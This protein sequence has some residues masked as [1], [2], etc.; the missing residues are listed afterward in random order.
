MVE[1]SVFKMIIDMINDDPDYI[2]TYYRKEYDIIIVETATIERC[3]S[4]YGPYKQIATIYANNNGIDVRRNNGT[5]WKSIPWSTYTDGVL[6]ECLTDLPISIQPCKTKGLQA[7]TFLNTGDYMITC[8]KD[9]FAFLSNFWPCMVEY[10]G[11]IFPSSEHAFQAAKTDNLEDRE[12]IAALNS[13]GKAKRAGKNMKLREGWA[14]KRV[15]VMREIL[16]IK[17]SDPD[18]R[19]LLVA[20]RPH[21]LIEGNNWG[22]RFWGVSGGKG[23]NTL[24]KLLMEVRDNAG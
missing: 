20:T 15:D 19:R 18:L 22:D 6:M 21:E 3:V 4:M 13:P 7:K 17:F 24:G 1:P 14:G 23:E 16:R 12:R 2:A 8:F 9:E 11:I 10:E 5:P